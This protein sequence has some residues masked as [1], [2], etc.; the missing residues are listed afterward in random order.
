MR[1]SETAM[2]G[3]QTA[4]S[5]CQETAMTGGQQKVLATACSNLALVKYWGKAD[6]ETNQPA[7]PSLSIGLEALT[8]TTELTVSTGTE[9]EI[10]VNNLQSGK[11][12]DRVRA[13]LNLCRDRYGFQQAFRLVSQNNFPTASGLA[14]SASGFAALSL[15][16]NQLMQLKLPDKQL[17]QLARRGSGS[18]ARSIFGGFVEV[19]LEEDAFARP[20]APAEH[21]PLR[22]V[23]VITDLAE[24]KPSSGEGMLRVAATSPHYQGWLD[25]HPNALDSAKQAIQ[26]RDFELLAKTSEANCMQMHLSIMTAEPPIHYWT[27]STIAVINKIKAL[28]VAGCPVFFTIDA[29]PQVLAVCPEGTEGAIEQALEAVPGVIRIITS[30]VG[31]SPQVHYAD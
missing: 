23:I 18:A 1:G 5:G 2:T 14:S 11:P 3:Y 26:E 22:V 20:F 9:D 4:M 25:A 21:W 24:K 31:G 6:P 19:V 15:A 17:S 30:K 13:Y 7:T 10:S 27:E 16:I 8:T 29:G 28:R 12:I